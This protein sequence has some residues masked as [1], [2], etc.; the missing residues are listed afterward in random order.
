MA[1]DSIMQRAC[2][3][4]HFALWNAGAPKDL[5]LNDMLNL[6]PDLSRI[7]QDGAASIEQQQQQPAQQQ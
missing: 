2:I 3:C 5:L 1:V 6:W 4:P 7:L